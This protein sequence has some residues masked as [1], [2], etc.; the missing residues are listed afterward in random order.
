MKPRYRMRLISIYETIDGTITLRYQ[1]ER[2]VMWFWWED[3]T[4]GFLSKE[5]AQAVLEKLLREDTQP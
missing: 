3:I 2:R 4:H 1:V 5:N